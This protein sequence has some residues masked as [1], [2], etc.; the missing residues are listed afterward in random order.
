M[1]LGGVPE[2][3]KKSN[4]TVAPDRGLFSANRKSYAVVRLLRG[5]NLETLFRELGVTAATEEWTCSGS[6]GQAS[7]RRT[8]RGS[9]GDRGCRSVPGSSC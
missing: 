1:P 8:S 2:M 9:T 7:Q 5:E 6:E 4:K 3:T